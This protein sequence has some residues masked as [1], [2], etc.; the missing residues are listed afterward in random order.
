[1]KLILDYQQECLEQ[2][3]Y[4]LKTELPELSKRLD[5]LRSQRDLESKANIVYRGKVKH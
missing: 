5:I 1:M 2:L 3:K 4:R